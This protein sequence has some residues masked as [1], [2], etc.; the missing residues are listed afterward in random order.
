MKP[1]DD[2]W[3]TRMTGHQ[4]RLIGTGGRTA[5]GSTS[6]RYRQDGYVPVYLGEFYISSVEFVG[7]ISDGYINY[8][9]GSKVNNSRE[10][11]ESYAKGNATLFWSSLTNV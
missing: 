11:Q 7:R 1:L 2:H 10:N 3:V 9:S 6:P 4:L 8:T 5:S